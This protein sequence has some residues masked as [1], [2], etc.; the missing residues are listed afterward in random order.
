MSVYLA[1]IGRNLPTRMIDNAH[2]ETYLDTSDAWIQD[3]T[4]I[5]V[6]YF[7][8][9]DVAASDLAFPACQEAIASAGVEPKDIDAV[10]V[11]TVTPDHSF[12]STACV[13]Q[14]RLGLRNVPAFDMMAACSGFIYGSEIVRGLISTGAYRNVLVVAVETLSKY[15]DLNDRNTAVL[16]GDAASA[17]VYTSEPGRGHGAKIISSYITASG[18]DRDLLCLPAG[19]SR[20]P[21]CAETV[22]A[23]DHYIKMQGQAVFKSAVRM[24]IESIKEGLAR[25]ELR[26]EDINLYIPHQANRRIIDAIGH[27]FQLD[28]EKVYVTV[29]KYANSSSA[30]IPVS[31]YDALRDGSIQKGSKVLLC[32]FGAGFTWGSMVVEF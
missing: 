2:F 31:L 7:V 3:R 21:A 11:C 13:L 18:K 20:R 19:G 5:K 14:D 30:T 23:G 29:D 4:G 26:K 17:V 8:D 9:K 6:R 28:P 25:A 32:S 12:P 16:F 10:V 15:L 22:E 24:M 27:F 1:G